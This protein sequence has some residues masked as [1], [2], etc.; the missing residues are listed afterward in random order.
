MNMSTQAYLYGAAG[1]VFALVFRRALWRF[2]TGLEM[3]G[4]PRTNHTAFHRGDK[5]LH[6]SGRAGRWGR[7]SYAERSLIRLLTAGLIGLAVYGWF[8]DRTLTGRIAVAVAVAVILA[9]AAIEYRKIR[10]WHH[11]RKYVLPLHAALAPVLGVDLSTRPESWLSVPLGFNSGDGKPVTVKLP[12]GFTGESRKAVES[13][14]RSK[15][16]ISEFNAEF[17]LIGAPTAEFRKAPRP[18]SKVMLDDVR[19]LVDQAPAGSPLV[20][21]GTRGVP[22]SVDLDAESPHV[23]VSAGSGGG[24]SVLLRF[25]LAQGLHNGG[26]GL[27][28]DVK[29]V[30]QAWA[31]GLPNVHYCRSI[32]T[33]HEALLWAKAEV[34]RR[35]DLIDDGAD[36]SGNVDHVDVGPRLFI[37][38]EEMNATINRLQAYWKEIKEKSDPATSP[39]V[40]ALGDV[41]FMGRAGKVH[42]LAVAQMMTARTL[43]GPEARENFATRILARYTVNNWKMLCPE[44]WPAP[45]SS[46]HAGRAQVVI[47]GQARET[48]V[49]FT[50]P[51]EARQL[52]VSGQVAEFPAYGSPVVSTQTQTQQT[53]SPVDHGPESP[54]RPSEAEAGPRSLHLVTESE[55]APVGLS[56][57]VTLG[58][59]S[60]V[61]LEAARVARKR[62]PE[63]PQPVGKRGTELLYRPGDLTRWERNRP[64]AKVA[65]DD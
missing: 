26:I 43:G 64:R 34:D 38:A 65:G 48:Q 55:P 20:G 52:S 8:T 49:A 11:R 59:L 63:F 16:G 22:V 56:E 13:I 7:L 25:L 31:R 24:K 57:A 53:G 61:T 30:S 14:V 27:I 62:D 9:V 42:V 28:L 17:R 40:Q 33:I 58:A 5:V 47:A 2:L 36:T 10:R 18:P 1:L 19:E 3:T 21:L 44:V 54:T 50:T 32:E 41:L 39:A 35:Y 12:R 37:L 51:D 45:K 29:R 60:E 23:L 6:V 46:R 15:L 4:R